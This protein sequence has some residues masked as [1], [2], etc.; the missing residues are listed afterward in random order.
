MTESDCAREGRRERVQRRHAQMCERLLSQS[1]RPRRSARESEELN[2]API[3]RAERFAHESAQSGASPGQL[4]DLPRD[5]SFSR[6]KDSAA[7][8]RFGRRH[9]ML[10]SPPRPS[11]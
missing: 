5:N 1:V 6:S 8:T 11:S 3:G 4:G 7:A 2:R 10:P 9:A